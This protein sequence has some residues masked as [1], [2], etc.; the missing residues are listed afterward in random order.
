MSKFQIA[1]MAVFGFFIVVAVIVFAVYKGSSST[2]G[3]VT[4]WGSLPSGSFNALL[5]EATFLRESGTSIVYVE[6]RAETLEAD[7]TEALAQGR[8]PDLLLLTQDKLWKTHAKLI[9]IPYESVSQQDFQE[10]FAEGAEIFLAPEGVYALPL[11]VDPLVLYYNRDLL[12]AAGIAQ[13]LGYWDEVYTATGSLTKR[14]DAGNITQS[15]IALGET[16]NIPRA[17]D[18]V[19][20]LL[21]QAGTPITSFDGEELR[22][23]LTN[24]FNLPI[25]PAESGFDFYTQFANPAKT[26][27]SWNRTLPEAQT[28]FTAGDS[29]Y[30][31]GFAS[32]YKTL[33]S[34]SPTLNFALTSVPQSRV[35]SR[36]ATLGN[37]YALAISRGS[38]NPQAAL[39][40]ALALI[41]QESAQVL[42]GIVALPPVRR[43]LL[44]QKLTDAV[45]P[46]FYTAALQAQSWLDPDPAATQK[47]FTTAIESITSGRAR[48][49]E[50]I[51]AADNQLEDLIN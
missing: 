43:D 34:K 47:I 28:S 14:D 25:S 36:R 8:G 9:P 44:S 38:S 37:F 6:K 40:T 41:S 42:A 26:F 2:Q 20:L 33:K 29:V 51:N 39:T 46:V 45:G 12:S 7:F 50:A 10:T 3:S 4:I 18:I 22:S 23:E 19:S 15:T 49:S 48:T 21:I 24:N 31:L 16:R 35:A 1:L 27:Y 30:Y 17:K 32:E 5:N 11:L 13:P